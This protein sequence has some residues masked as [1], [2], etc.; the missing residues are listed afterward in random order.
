MQVEGNQNSQAAAKLG[1]TGEKIAKK[2]KY[3][4]SNAEAK[5]KRRRKAKV[6]A[7]KTPKK[8][9]RSDGYGLTPLKR[10]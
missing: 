10:S 1:H 5:L 8:W 9:S 7:E 4:V 6:E 3:I 2:S